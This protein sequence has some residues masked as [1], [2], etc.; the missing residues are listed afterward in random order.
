MIR[1]QFVDEGQQCGKVVRRQLIEPGVFQVAVK[2]VFVIAHQL[3][4][5]DAFAGASYTCE[6]QSLAGLGRH[7]LYQF[8]AQHRSGHCRRPLVRE[9][10]RECI[11]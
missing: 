7:H 8:P 6:D 9:D 10:L 4:L 11:S 3:G 1:R 5:Q 2:Q